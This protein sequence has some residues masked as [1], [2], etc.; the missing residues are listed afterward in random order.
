MTLR[1]NITS[2]LLACM[3]IIAG[4]APAADFSTIAIFI[5]ID[6]DGFNDNDRDDDKNG[7]PDRFEP[8]EITEETEVS[9]LLGDVFNAQVTELPGDL[10][11]KSGEFGTR[12]F[13]TR[14]LWQCHRGLSS[15]DQFGPGNG[16][17]LGAAAC[18]G[19]VCGI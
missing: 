19:G 18:D 15:D 10:I 2:A 9:S 12:K 16:I 5:D 11:S 4:T 6:G 8:G 13:E 3:L 1:T 14:L 7:I 17:G